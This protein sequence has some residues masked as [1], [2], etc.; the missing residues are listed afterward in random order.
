VAGAKG[1]LEGALEGRRRRRKGRTGDGR[2]RGLGR[3]DSCRAGVCV[4][5]GGG[6]NEG[7]SGVKERTAHGTRHRRSPGRQDARS[8]RLAISGAFVRGANQRAPREG[9]CVWGLTAPRQTRQCASLF[10]CPSRRLREI[11]CVFSPPPQG[12][13][14]PRTPASLTLARVRRLFVLLR[15]C[16]L[17]SSPA[18]AASG[19]TGGSCIVL[20]HGPAPCY[21]PC[22]R[23]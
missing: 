6:R 7:L 3:A 4:R 11:D 10:L 13:S 2:R 12:L 9:L 14:P 8:G 19:P 15:R 23:H 21:V 20:Q 22:T 17:Y 1:R 5:A 18:L 16:F